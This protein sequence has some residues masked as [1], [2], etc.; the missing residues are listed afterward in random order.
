MLY[1]ALLRHRPCDLLQNYSSI[2]KIC[3]KFLFPYWT[4][5]SVRIRKLNNGQE[6]P[7]KYKIDKYVLFSNMSNI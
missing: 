3:I 6:K 7:E 2:Q 4:V 5:V 1:Y